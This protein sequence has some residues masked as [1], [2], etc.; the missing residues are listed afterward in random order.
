MM[1]QLQKGLNKQQKPTKYYPTLQNGMAMTSLAI[2]ELITLVLVQEDL[3][4][5]LLTIFL[6]IYSEIFLVGMT[7]LE[8]DKDLIEVL[9][10]NTPYLFL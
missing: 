6:E 4:Q 2:K 8:E 1:L 9:I 10:C 3:L 5:M 7:L